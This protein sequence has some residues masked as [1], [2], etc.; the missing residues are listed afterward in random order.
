VVAV[1][2]ALSFSLVGRG[3]FDIPIHALAA[4]AAALWLT[5]AVTD[6]RALWQSLVAANPRREPP[7]GRVPAA[8]ASR[9]SP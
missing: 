1:V 9:R 2:A 4:C 3:A 8:E 6:P 7:P 5:V